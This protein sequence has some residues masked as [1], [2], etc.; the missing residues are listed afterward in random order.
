MSARRTTYLAGVCALL[1][2]LTACTGEAEPGRAGTEPT[3]AGSSSPSEPAVSETVAR[4]VVLGDQEVSFEVGPVRVQDGVGLLSVQATEVDP[5]DGKNGANVDLALSDPYSDN[6]IGPSG[7]RLVDTAAGTVSTVAIDGAD[8]AVMTTGSSQLSDEPVTMVAGFAAPTGETVDVLLPY[9]GYFVGVPVLTEADDGAAAVALADLTDS[10]TADLTLPVATLDRY[11]EDQAGA[12]RTRTE[13]EEVTVAIAADVLFA[14]D[15]SDLGPQA[16]A[17][18]ASAGAQIAAYSAGALTVVGHT[19][20]VASDEYNQD[21]SVRRAQ[22]VADRLATLVDLAPYPPAVEGRGE[23]EPAAAGSS[24]EARAS[25][26]RVELLFT[27]SADAT[28]AGEEPAPV[29]ELPAAEG[30]VG[31]GAA[32]VEVAFLKDAKFAVSLDE[33]QRVGDTL[34]GQVRVERLAGG[35]ANLAHFF[36]AGA[37]GS[38]GK[39]DIQVQWAATKLTL[40]QGGTRYF[41]L[42]YARD[43]LGQRDPLADR[44]LS[45][46]FGDGEVQTVTVVWPSVPGDTV[47]LDAPVFRSATDAE[48]GGPA[49]RL[50]DIPVVEP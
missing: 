27:P 43:D 37:W 14:A 18:L 29:G 6:R 7:A 36:S 28:H 32:G 45:T 20:D 42:D 15:S 4:T 47:A 12:V 30:P 16:D 24:P 23:S 9:V 49:F 50:T 17:A 5:G 1:V 10:A 8:H 44:Y 41:P 38:R 39:L 22:S 13:A 25:N 19:D 11:T 46:P 35:R 48:S 3:P 2:G 40:L 34:V 33:V 26:R 21:L 31:T